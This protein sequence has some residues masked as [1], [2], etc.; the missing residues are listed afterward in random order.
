MK[1]TACLKFTSEAE[2][3]NSFPF[4]NIKITRHNQQF[5]KSVYRK[6]TFRGVFTHYE[7]YVNPTYQKS[8]TDTLL[9]RCF[10]IFSDY[11]S[12]HLEVKNL[13]EILKNNSY[14]LGIIE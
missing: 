9:F 14:P 3:D 5:K 12:F 1:K 2:N 8:L 6:P 7:G 11:T 10:S 13:R 4:P